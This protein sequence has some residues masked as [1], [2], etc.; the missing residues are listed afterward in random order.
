MRFRTVRRALFTEEGLSTFIF[1]YARDYNW[2]DGKASVDSDLLRMIRSVTRHLEVGRC[3]EGEWERAIVQGFAVSRGIRKRGSGTL[4]VN[5][6]KRTITVKDK[7]PGN[8]MRIIGH[9]IDMVEIA[10]IQTC[11]DSPDRNGLNAFIRPTNASRPI[12]HHSTSAITPG[13]SPARKPWQK[14]SVPGFPAR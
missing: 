11:L 2:L 12:S 7:S 6:D 13:D 4:V 1:A 14:P 9:G 10:R 3:T 8:A 5:L